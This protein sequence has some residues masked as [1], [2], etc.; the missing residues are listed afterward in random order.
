MGHI[1]ITPTAENEVFT[2][3]IVSVSLGI[4][5]TLLWKHMK[6]HQWLSKQTVFSTYKMTVWKLKSMRKPTLISAQC[7]QTLSPHNATLSS[8]VVDK[9]S[10]KLIKSQSMSKTFI[11]SRAVLLRYKFHFLSIWF[12]F[13]WAVASLIQILTPDLKGSSFLS[14]DEWILTEL[15]KALI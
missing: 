7:E 4:M 12:H 5:L 11:L 6:I 8:S 13:L 14:L 15:I 10:S 1:Q 2:Q 3:M 9:I